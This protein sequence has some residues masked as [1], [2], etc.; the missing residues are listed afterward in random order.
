[1]PSSDRSPRIRAR[2][3]SA[4]STLACPS[5]RCPRS[6]P[7]WPRRRRRAARALARALVEAIAADLAQRG[8]AAVEAYPDLTLDADEASA[9]TPAF[10]ER[11]GFELAVSDERYPVMRRELE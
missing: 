5:H 8:F 10:W 7:A 3:I 6:S 9:A 1:M 2:S 4:S 11:C